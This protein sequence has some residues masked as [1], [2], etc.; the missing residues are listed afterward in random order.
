EQPV[1]VAPFLLGVLEEVGE[2]PGRDGIL[3]CPLPR[4]RRRGLEQGQ[5]CPHG[6]PEAEQVL[7]EHGVDRRVLP[8]LATQGIEPR[9]GQ[10]DL[11]A[12]R[13]AG[14]E[15]AHGCAQERWTRGT[16]AA[17]PAWR[18]PPSPGGSPPSS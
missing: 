8:Q 15:T 6:G 18:R 14:A 5:G 1:I 9:L 17:R 2:E 12:E 10:A 11:E 7:R 13:L 3:P 4:P 16:T